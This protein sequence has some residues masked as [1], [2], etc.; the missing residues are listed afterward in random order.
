MP[1]YHHRHHHRSRRYKHHRKYTI[2]RPFGAS[3]TCRITC[4]FALP[5]QFPDNPGGVAVGVDYKQALAWQQPSGLITAVQGFN[6]ADSQFLQE[7]RNWQEFQITG[8]KLRWIPS[9]V[10]GIATGTQFD[11]GAYL[12]NFWLIDVPDYLNPDNVTD[13]EYIN[14]SNFISVDPN[15]PYHCYKDCRPISAQQNVPWQKTTDYSAGSYNT[16]TRATTQ[17]KFKFFIPANYSTVKV[18]GYLI[19]SWYILFRG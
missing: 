8:C 10:V 4:R 7:Y 13:K 6:S 9:D 16:L 15:K 11:G 14:R 2:E 18:A 5:V 12:S 3:R 1:K 19:Y 17:M